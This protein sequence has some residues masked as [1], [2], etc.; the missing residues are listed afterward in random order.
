M[1]RTV[2]LVS[3]DAAINWMCSRDPTEQGAGGGGGAGTWWSTTICMPA[4]IQ[5]AVE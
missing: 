2:I 1:G 5:P 4:T 3:H